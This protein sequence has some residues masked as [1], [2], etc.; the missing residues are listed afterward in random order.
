MIIT[1]IRDLTKKKKK[2]ILEDESSFCLYDSEVR[3]FRLKE[4]EELSGEIY[5]RIVNEILKKRGISRALHLLLV[6]IRTRK[7]L[8]E[9]LR[10]DGYP[11]EVVEEAIAYAEKFHYLDDAEYARTY[12]AGRGSRKGSRMVAMELTQKGVASSIV[13]EVMEER[14]EETE[15]DLARNLAAKKLG[16]K[17]VIDEGEYR[18]CWGFLTRRG[19]SSSVIGHVLREYEIDRDLEA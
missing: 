15:Y 4:G 16:A 7:E 3:R 1:Q 9:R 17:K 8:E 14:S 6:Q 19:F 2:I 12:L 18:R 10:R 11:E 13:E 5:D